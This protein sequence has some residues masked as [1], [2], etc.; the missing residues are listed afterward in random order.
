LVALPPVEG[1]GGDGAVVAQALAAAF[2]PVLRKHAD[3]YYNYAP[4]F[5]SKEN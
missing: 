2:E 5:A 3:E 1:G 4:L